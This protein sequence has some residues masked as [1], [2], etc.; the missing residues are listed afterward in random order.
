[1]GRKAWSKIVADLVEQRRE[2][3]DEQWELYARNV[4]TLPVRV[5]PGIALVLVSAIA[6]AW[7]SP[8]WSGVLPTPAPHLFAIALAVLSAAAFA[9][10]VAVFARVQTA[11]PPFIRPRPTSKAAFLLREWSASQQRAAIIWCCAFQAYVAALAFLGVRGAQAA[12]SASETVVAAIFC[13]SLVVVGVATA[14]LVFCIA[15][16]Q[17]EFDAAMRGRAAQIGFWSALMVLG[18]ALIATTFLGP[19]ILPWLPFGF[20]LMIVAPSLSFVVLTKPSNTDG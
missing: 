8:V 19:A 1:V 10:F 14:V 2:K 18:S 20:M 17:D 15:R 3:V 5:L 11:P 13:I 6:G 12:P 7:V 4:R 9:G 16:Q